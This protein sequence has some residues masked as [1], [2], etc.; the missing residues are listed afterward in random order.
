MEHLEGRHLSEHLD[1]GTPGLWNTW[2]EGHHLSEQQLHFSFQVLIN[3]SLDSLF[4]SNFCHRA[5]S[6]SMLVAM[7]VP[8]LLKFLSKIPNY[9]FDWLHFIML[10]NI[11]P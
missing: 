2:R 11:A 3:L 9:S 10:V 6:A 1:L 5:P 4:I 8:T 7:S